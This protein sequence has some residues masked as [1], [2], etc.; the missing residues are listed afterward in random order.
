VAD[1]WIDF[2]TKQVEAND[3]PVPTSKELITAASE[4]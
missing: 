3:D 2:L 4:L 1:L